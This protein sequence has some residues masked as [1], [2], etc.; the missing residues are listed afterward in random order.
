MIKI[1][2]DLF[3]NTFFRIDFPGASF[4]FCSISSNYSAKHFAAIWTLK[5]TVLR[6]NS[7]KLKLIFSS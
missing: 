4:P 6:E 1:L 3:E 2:I 5:N 7:S